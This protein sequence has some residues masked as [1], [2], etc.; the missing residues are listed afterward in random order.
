MRKN[1]QRVVLATAASPS[2][3]AVRWL[4]SD[5]RD[6]LPSGGI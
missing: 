3:A 5:P 6:T 2:E 1:F 4:S